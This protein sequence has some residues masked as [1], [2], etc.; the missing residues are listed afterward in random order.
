MLG[1]ARSRCELTRLW[2]GFSL[3]RVSWNI[4]RLSQHLITRAV[5]PCNPLVSGLCALA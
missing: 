2:F 3:A 1:T 4:E 5:T